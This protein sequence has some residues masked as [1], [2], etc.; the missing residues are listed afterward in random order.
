MD[1]LIG[2]QNT[3]ECIYEFYTWNTI[4][5]DEFYVKCNSH[6][7]SLLFKIINKSHKKE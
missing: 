7:E 6:C 2:I 1:I 3:L 4:E 5:G